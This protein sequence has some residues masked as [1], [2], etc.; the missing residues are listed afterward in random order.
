MIKGAEAI[1]EQQ[2]D[3][4]TAFAKMLASRTKFDQLTLGPKEVEPPVVQQ[5]TMP[6]IQENDGQSLFSSYYS[7]LQ[8]YKIEEDSLKD[9]N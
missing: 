1:F 4:I 2:K 7:F 8:R 9:P 3:E 5:P 6:C